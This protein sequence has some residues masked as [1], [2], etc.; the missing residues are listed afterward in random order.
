MNKKLLIIFSIFLASCSNPKQEAANK[1]KL[2]NIIISYAKKHFGENPNIS[3]IYRH[4][5][6]KADCTISSNTVNPTSVTCNIY[7][8]SCRIIYEQY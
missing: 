4:D 8:E 2:Y 1:Q 3:C 7:Y 6:A 5:F